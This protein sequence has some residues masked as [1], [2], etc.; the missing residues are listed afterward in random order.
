VSFGAS[1][2]LAPAAE[3]HVV[4][5]REHLAQLRDLLVALPATAADLEAL[6]ASIRQLDE[7]FMIV[8]VGEF[9]AGKSAFV[10]ALLGERVFE[11]TFKAW[12][13]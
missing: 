4:E 12:G 7:L 10:N 1:R 9:N 13:Q 5:V 8:V 6:V 2:L 11:E 3:R